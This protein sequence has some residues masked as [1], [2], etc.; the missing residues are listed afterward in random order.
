ME[1]LVSVDDLLVKKIM[2]TASIAGINLPVKND[3]LDADL[4][5]LEPSAKSILLK[6]TEGF[7]SQHCAIMRFLANC[8]PASELV[9]RTDFDSSQVST[10]ISNFSLF[11]NIFY[12]RLING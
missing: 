8:C 11:R 4:L 9:G 5:A 10:Y 1:L 6:T 12:S 7:I 2:V 3:C